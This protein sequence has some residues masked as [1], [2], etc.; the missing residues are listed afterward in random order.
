MT[1]QPAPSNVKL[2]IYRITITIPGQS[3]TTYCTDLPAMG[4]TTEQIAMFPKHTVGLVYK[5]SIAE[6]TSAEGLI[7][8][9]NGYAHPDVPQELVAKLVDG[10]YWTPVT[11]HDSPTA[12]QVLSAFIDGEYKND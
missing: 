1:N 6:D 10:S 5:I 4:I 8:C 7:N 11:E 9:L 12:E 3:L 2:V